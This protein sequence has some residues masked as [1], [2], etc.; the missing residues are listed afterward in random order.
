MTVET[1]GSVLMSLVAID[2]KTCTKCKETKELKLFSALATS[3]DGKRK[4]CKACDHLYRLANQDEIREY[5]YQN[6]YGISLNEYEEKLKEQDYS[7]AICGS[8]HTSNERMKRLVVDHDHTTGQVRGL[9]CHSCNVAIGA[10]K[11]QEDILMACIS[12]LRS[13]TKG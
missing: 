5:H 13:Y 8:K 2:M 6:R 9:L 10:A 12:Y 11:E 4:Q 3:K 1:N 7:C